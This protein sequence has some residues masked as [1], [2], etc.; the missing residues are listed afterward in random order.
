MRSPFHEDVQHEP[1]GNLFLKASDHASN[2]EA[3]QSR[4]ICLVSLFILRPCDPVERGTARS[5]T[6][7]TSPSPAISHPASRFYEANS[8]SAAMVT[9]LLRGS[10]AMPTAM[11]AC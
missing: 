2:L 7:H 4:I 1:T 3:R 8:T 9:A 5:F 10:V 11:R 6:E